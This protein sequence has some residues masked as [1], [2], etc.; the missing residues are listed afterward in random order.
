MKKRTADDSNCG[1]FRKNITYLR[2]Y[3]KILHNIS[4]VNLDPFG[5]TAEDMLMFWSHCLTPFNDWMCWNQMWE[6]FESR[7]P[8]QSL[9][10]PVLKRAWMKKALPI[11][12]INVTTNCIN[13]QTNKQI[14]VALSRTATL[15]IKAAQLRN[16]RPQRDIG[17]S[18]DS[19]NKDPQQV[20]VCAGRS[21]SNC[22]DE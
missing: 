11:L 2:F 5:K 12:G 14:S 18:A 10:D 22:S 16:T 9:K 13:K 1:V 3:F 17:S 15:H 21:G 8:S 19:I 7:N 6:V 4:I 20:L